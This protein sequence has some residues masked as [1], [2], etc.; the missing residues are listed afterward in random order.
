MAPA[1]GIRKLGFR[2]WYE[3]ELI[4][5]HVYF[6]TCFLCLIVVAVCLEQI[7]WNDPVSEFPT[8]LYIVG[9]VA[10]GVVSLRRYQ[11]ILVRAECLGS[12]S[13]CPQCRAYGALQVREAGI[14]RDAEGG[15]DNPWLE[16]RCRKC[17]H[18]WRMES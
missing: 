10:L 12:Q 9:G 5:G 16:V 13:V 8:L 2:R 11:R 15:A 14:A 7:D 6:V 4:E 1:E 18:D 3:R 17:G